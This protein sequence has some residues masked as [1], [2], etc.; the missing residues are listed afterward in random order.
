MGA[1]GLLLIFLV[2]YIIML[3]PYF[4][5]SPNQILIEPL[6]DGVDINIVHRSVEFIHGKSLFSLDEPQLAKKIQE[7]LLNVEQIRIDKLYPNGVKILIKSLPIQFDVTIFGLEN[8]RWG[9]SSNGVF[10]PMADM[11]NS[12]NLK[13]LQLI[14]T[15]LQSELFLNYKKI[16]SDKE[17]FVIRKIFE[18][19]SVE[20]TDLQIARANYFLKERELHIVLESN[21][22]IIFALNEDL[23]NWK[24]EISN[25]LLSQFITLKTYI[26]SH[27]EKLVEGN[28][29]YLDARISGKIFA[30]TDAN[31]CQ[32]NLVNIYGNAYQ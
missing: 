29:Y 23:Q 25:D 9:I 1:I 3:S 12:Q 32:K 16:L 7:N 18:V 15:N 4:K 24:N 27:R 5:I 31:I 21:T 22:K 10:I 2:G 8:K 26:S 30:C 11:K 6:S 13:H 14:S 28:L 20:W 17:M 19:F